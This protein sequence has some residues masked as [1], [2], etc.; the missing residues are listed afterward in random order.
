MNYLKINTNYRLSFVWIE[1]LDN[2]PNEALKSETVEKKGPV[3][4]IRIYL[5]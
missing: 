2:L 3:Q 1:L 4:S 5:R